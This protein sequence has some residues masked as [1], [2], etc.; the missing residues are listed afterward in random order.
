MCFSIE[1]LDRYVMERLREPERTVVKLHVAKCRHCEEIIEESKAMIGIL[2]LAARQ[3]EA[4][5]DALV[6]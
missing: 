2:L 6:D 1:T 4:D 3:P 5:I